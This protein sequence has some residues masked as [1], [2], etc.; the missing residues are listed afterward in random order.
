MQRKVTE[1]ER[2]S[3]CKLRNICHDLR[4]L[5]RGPYGIRVVLLFVFPVV[6]K[7]REETEPRM[8]SSYY[9]VFVT[10]A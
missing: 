7:S 4:L 5:K 9:Q 2:K 6:N 1:T 10:T 3:F 8:N